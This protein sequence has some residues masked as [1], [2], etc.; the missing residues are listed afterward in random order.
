MLVFLVRREG[1]PG[2]EGREIGQVRQMEER[3]DKRNNGHG[4]IGR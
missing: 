1:G 4:F 2:R 3:D